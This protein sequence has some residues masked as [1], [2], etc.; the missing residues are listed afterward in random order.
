MTWSGR[1]PGT[2]DLLA[3]ERTLSGR[4]DRAHPPVERP[5]GLDRPLQETGAERTRAHDD[6]IS[7][8]RSDFVDV[9]S[10]L[11]HSFHG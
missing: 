4:P 8:A 9:F 5:T 3:R 10:D 2:F 6:P 1:P 7:C 11:E